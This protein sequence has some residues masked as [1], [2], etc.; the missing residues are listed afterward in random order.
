[1][2][3]YIYDGPVL[4]FN[5]CITNRWYGYTYAPSEKKALS[6]LKYQFKKTN[7]RTANSKITLPGKIISI[8]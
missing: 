6:N 7:N 4:E 8:A 1:M 5:T 2:N 3:K